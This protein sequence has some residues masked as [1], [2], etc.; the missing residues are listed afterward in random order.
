V[1]PEAAQPDVSVVVVSF[2]TRDLLARCLETVREQ[3][4]P[5]LEVVVVDNGSTD[6]SVRYVRERFPEVT[7]LPLGENRGFAAANNA[8]FARCRGEYVL[9]LNSDTFLHDGA[10]A[11]LVDAARRHPR[12]AAVGPRLLNGDG[13]LQRSAW[14]F[15]QARRLLLEAVTLHRPLARLGLVE[16]LRLWAHDDERAV[17]FLIGACLL[18][19]RHALDEVG[20]FDEGF[21]L[22]GEEADLCWRLSQRGWQVVLAPDA[23]ATH[24]GGA[25]SAASAPR[26]RHFYRGQKRFLLKHGPRGAWAL[27]RL[28]LV[29]GSLLRGRWTVVRV[30]LDRTL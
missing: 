16:D 28:A 11:A 3:A 19:R 13:S 30:A 9:L 14:P 22:Y 29:L 25:S 18:V 21:W 17:D 5:S 15:P 8:A 26:L 24:V 4:G 1:S 27:A 23:V 7:V 6:G 2:N 12:A 10:L 20:G